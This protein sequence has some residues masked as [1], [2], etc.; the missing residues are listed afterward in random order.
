MRLC[1]EVIVLF[2][3]EVISGFRVHFAGASGHYDIQPDIASYGKIIGGGFPVGAYAGRKEIMDCVAP[4][5][6]VYQAGTLSGNPVAMTAGYAQ[7]SECL[8]LGFYEEQEERTKYFV[9]SIN[10]FCEDRDFEFRLTTI[11]SIFWCKFTTETIRKSSEIDANKMPTFSKL[12]HSLLRK[13]VYLGP[14]G[15]EVGFVSSAHSYQ[16]LDNALDKFKS[17]LEEI[18]N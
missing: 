2:F 16:V 13:G 12:F 5:G 15:Y 8:K 1:F 18:F 3:D 10:K 17:A 14:S 9:D 6:D 4:L 7:L 11:G